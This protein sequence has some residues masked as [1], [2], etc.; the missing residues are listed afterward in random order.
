MVARWTWR[1]AV[2]C[3]GCWVVGPWLT[4]VNAGRGPFLV[5]EGAHVHCAR[6]YNCLPELTMGR[7]KGRCA[8]NV[9]A[10]WRLV[11]V[12]LASAAEKIPVTLPGAVG[13]L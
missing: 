1:P 9:G 4:V 6:A 2:L 5:R 12:Y 7:V 11:S 8:P 13:W 10:I 3:S